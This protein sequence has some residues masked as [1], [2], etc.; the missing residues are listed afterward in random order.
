M[1]IEV[2]LLDDAGRIIVN[3]SVVPTVSISRLV[4]AERYQVSNGDQIISSEVSSS[5]KIAAASLRNRAE[6]VLYSSPR[7]AVY[8]A[9]KAFLMSRL[10]FF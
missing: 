3:D 1:E 8:L 6:A 2:V 4:S 5:S 9:D 7:T 10:L